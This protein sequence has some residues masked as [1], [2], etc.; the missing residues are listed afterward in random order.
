MIKKQNFFYLLLFII[1]I[2][3]NKLFA[4]TLAEE[5][6]KLPFYSGETLQ[7]QLSYRGLLTS[8]IWADIA[9]AE[10]V[11]LANKKTPE[12]QYGYQFKL[13]LSTEKYTKSEII[14]P[15]RYTYTA[16]LDASMQ[17]TLLIEKMDT[18]A[19][20]SHDF[21]WLDWFNKETQIYK[22][23]VKKL[24]YS[25]LLWADEEEVWEED[26]K[27]IIPDFLSKFPLLD[28]NQ[29]YLVHKGSGGKINHSQILEPL[30]LIYS[31]RTDN[32]AEK[33]D[34][35][36]IIKEDIR[37]YRVEHLGLEE[38][39]VNKI[40]FQ[41]IKYKIQRNNN[42]EKRFFIWI[43]NDKNKLPLRIAMDAP[44]GKLEIQL[45]KLPSQS[46]LAASFY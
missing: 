13:L 17:R 45:T 2:Y 3:F 10:I 18:G 11:F 41:A 20:K 26:G 34:T 44:L 35:S 22:K 46:R 27:E 4:L 16:T 23:R 28:K 19:S 40:K 39:E 36:V 14:H 1:I 33:Q 9:D 25:G 12:Q 30:S 5:E 21:L 24:I 15:V 32:F 42:K 31:L 43:S 6:G 37:L 29:S 7:Y 38:I 8:M